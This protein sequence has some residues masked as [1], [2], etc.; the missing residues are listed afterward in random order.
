MSGTDAGKESRVPVLKVLAIAIVAL[1]VGVGVSFAVMRGLE[2]GP[3]GTG[4]YRGN[5]S[6]VVARYGTHPVLFTRAGCVYC[7]MAK[8]YLDGKGIAYT[9]VRLERSPADRRYFFE[10]MGQSGVPV[11]VAPAH[12][13]VGFDRAL[14]DHHVG[15]LAGR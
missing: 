3:S 6:G 13:V 5:Y 8:A 15:P 14:Y 4:V 9:E 12:L 7:G 10:E 1:V 2:S 11:F